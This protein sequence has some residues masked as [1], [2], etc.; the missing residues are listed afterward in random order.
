MSHKQI[1]LGALRMFFA[2]LVGAISGAIAACKVEI[3]RSSKAMGK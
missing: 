3:D 1:F 2:P